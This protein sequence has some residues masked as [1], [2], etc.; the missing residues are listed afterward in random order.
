MIF[1]QQ[2]TCMCFL[3]PSFSEGIDNTTVWIKIISNRKPWEVLFITFTSVFFCSKLIFTG[4]G[5]HSDIV[6]ST[7]SLDKCRHL[8]VGIEDARDVRLLLSANKLIRVQW[9]Y[10]YNF[11]FPFPR[12]TCF[13]Y[14]MIDR[15]YDASGTNQIETQ[16]KELCRTVYDIT[17]P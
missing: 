11:H 10:M 17:I 2:V 4:Q 1:I 3:T 8:K 7:Q 16:L 14:A 15:P 5:I 9:I 12:R 13:V 6:P